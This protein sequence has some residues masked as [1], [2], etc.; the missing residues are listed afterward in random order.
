[1]NVDADREDWMNGKAVLITGAS[2]GIGRATALFLARAGLCVF[3]GVRR[4]HDGERVESQ[5]AGRIRSVLLDVADDDSIARAR[6]TVD[7]EVGHAGLGGLVNNAAGGF[8]GPL[9]HTTR[10]D[11]DQVFE[12]NFHGVVL[13]TNAFLPLLRRARGRIVNVGG[14]G[15]GCMA[16]PLMGVGCASKYAVEGMT[17]ALRVELRQAGIKVSLVEPGMTYSEADKP[18]FRDAMNATFDL[19]QSRVPEEQKAH[20]APAL[21]RLRAFNG[22]FLDRAS[23]PEVIARRIHHA[24]TASRPRSRYW[25]GR[26]TKLAAALSRLTNAATRDFI[27]GRVTGL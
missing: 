13:T 1:M 18:V 7:R 8:G 20:Y 12:V 21:E 19:A 22:S 14:G 24:L 26:E 2:R 17:D 5:G 6:D 11:L 3:A 9:E 16:I 27:W 10:A 23:P 15:A 25:C 4:R